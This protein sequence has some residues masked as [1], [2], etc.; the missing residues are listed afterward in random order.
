MIIITM[1]YYYVVIIAFLLDAFVVVSQLRRLIFVLFYFTRPLRPH[2][3]IH[4]RE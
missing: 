1:H 4:A 2:F 3:Q